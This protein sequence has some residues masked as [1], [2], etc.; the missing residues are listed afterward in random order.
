VNVTLLAF[1][2]ECRAVASAAVQM[3]VNDCTHRAQPQIC[4]MLGLRSHDGTEEHDYVIGSTLYTMRAVAS[5]PCVTSQHSPLPSYVTHR[6][7][8]RDH[9][10]PL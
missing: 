9:P 6:H 5:V 7:T 8:S 1:A 3:V 4:R 2:A 10:L